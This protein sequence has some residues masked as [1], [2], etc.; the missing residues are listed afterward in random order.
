MT[1]K[2]SST[3]L[4]WNEFFTVF[5]VDRRRFA[6]FE[7]KVTQTGRA[8]GRGRI[9]LLW[10]NKLLAERKMRGKNLC[11]LQLVEQI[12]RDTNR[13]ILRCRRVHANFYRSLLG[14]AVQR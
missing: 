6:A 2:T 8:S 9:G 11:H 1:G 14:M 7:R 10:P 4:S 5:A 13:L 3:S 12:S